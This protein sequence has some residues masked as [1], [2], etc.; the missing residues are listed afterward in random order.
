MHQTPV[1]SEEKRAAILHALKILSGVFWG[2][3][4]DACQK[5]TNDDVFRPFDALA[6][7]LVFDPPD[8]LFAIRS[9]IRRFPDSDDLFRY[10]EEEYLK[11]FI[12]D[13]T[14]V[15]APLYASCYEG[16]HPLLMGSPAIRMKDRFAAAGLVLDEDLGEPPD[17]LSIELEFLYFLIERGDSGSSQ[18]AVAE[19]AAFAASAMIPWVRLFHE[20]LSDSSNITEP[21]F[22]S[23]A[24]SLLLSV[25]QF[26]AGL[27]VAD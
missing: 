26:I 2:P 4:P 23:L 1:L 18:G 13:R 16:E 9:V 22:Y 7:D 25:L 8:T 11:L 10:L 14:S 3:S 15:P 19:A 27:T 6:P 12:T 17:H 5:M 24:A 20:R 21:H